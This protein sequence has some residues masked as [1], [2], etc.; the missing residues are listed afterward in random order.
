MKA[1]LSSFTLVAILIPCGRAFAY[2]CKPFTGTYPEDLQ[3]PCVDLIGPRT[4]AKLKYKNSLCIRMK[5]TG[6]PYKPYS[7]GD[8]TE[9]MQVA[10]RIYQTDGG[11]TL[12]V[13]ISAAPL[14]EKKIEN[15]FLYRGDSQVPYEAHTFLL[16][17]NGTPCKEWTVGD[18]TSSELKTA[19]CEFNEELALGAAGQVADLGGVFTGARASAAV[20]WADF[21][22][23]DV[24]LVNLSFEIPPS[25]TFNF[26]E[27]AIPTLGDHRVRRAS[28][29]LLQFSQTETTKL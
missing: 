14:G 19:G 29:Q 21:S 8:A 11:R 5:D 10:T 20:H 16:T 22:D 2:D 17:T 23:P 3:T 24:G 25:L 28:S 13:T 6:V 26:P 12:L 18:K 4:P 15:Q 27:D 7:C 1:R 9:D